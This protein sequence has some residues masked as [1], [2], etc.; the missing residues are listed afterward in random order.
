[1]LDPLCH[2]A[3]A[4]PASFTGKQI[5][6]TFRVSFDLS[7]EFVIFFSVT[8]P[9]FSL[10]SIKNIHISQICK[11]IILDKISWICLIYNLKLVFLM[12]MI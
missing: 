5:R 9:D 1:M 7:H 3:S 12:I 6:D 10:T 4:E 2:N 11:I 8:I